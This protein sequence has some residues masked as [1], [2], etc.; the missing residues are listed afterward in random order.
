MIDNSFGVE[1]VYKIPY[2]KVMNFIPCVYADSGLYFNLT[3]TQGGNGY[4]PLTVPNNK[5]YIQNLTSE[6][7]D[8]VF[9]GLECES[10]I[11]VTTLKN[12]VDNLKNNIT[13]CATLNSFKNKK[14]GIIGD[15]IS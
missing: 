1:Y 3:S 9:F 14:V 2:G 7:L 5:T 15:S 12:D 11:N 13:V 10:I 4:V 6:K 8:D